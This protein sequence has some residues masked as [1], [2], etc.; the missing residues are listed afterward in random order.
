MA[1]DEALLGDAIENGHATLRFYQWS[2]PTL[3][4]GY[5][6]RYADRDQHGA[7]RASAIVRR[8]SGGGA[9]LHDRELTYSLVLPPG[10]PL[11]ARTPK[12]YASVHQAFI[13]ALSR[14]DSNNQSGSAPLNELRIRGDEPHASTDPKAT[15]DEPFLCFQ[16]RSPGDV[17]LLAS[18]RQRPSTTD[19]SNPLRVTEKILGSAQRRHR[20]A[21]LQHGSLLIEAS[22]AAPELPGLQDL[23]AGEIRI[24][25]LI[26]AVCDELACSL[27]FRFTPYELSS[28]LQSKAADL[29]NNKYGAA[30][31][32]N[33]R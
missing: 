16:R 27:H 31:W 23:A 24:D 10:H 13:A 29:A 12:L 20:G 21:I 3:S 15:A 25:S 2:E 5:F 26:P 1:V 30:C 11:S 9:I 7:S 6:Q 33:R 17:V 28:G 4:L 22:P 8:Q 14:H 32:T 18:S 19:T